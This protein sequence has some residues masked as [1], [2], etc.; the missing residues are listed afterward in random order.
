MDQHKVKQLEEKV[1]DV[2]KSRS[3]GNP[4]DRIVICHVESELFLMMA[5]LFIAKHKKYEL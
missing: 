1:L 4:D 3:T 2:L 5:Y